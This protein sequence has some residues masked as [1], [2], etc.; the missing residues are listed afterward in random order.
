MPTYPLQGQLIDGARL[1]EW[2]K[3]HIPLSAD[4][5]D[6]CSAF[7]KA[8]ALSK[9]LDLSS[10]LSGR[11][12]VRWRLSDIVAGVSDLSAYGLA[13]E[14]GLNVFLRL[15]F[16]GKVYALYGHAIAVGSANATSAGLALGSNSN[17][18]VATIVQASSENRRIVDALFVGATLITPQLFALLEQAVAKAQL[19]ESPDSN[20]NWPQD[21]SLLLEP[22]TWPARLLLSECF[23][24]APLSNAGA[25]DCPTVDLA[26]DL[27]LMGFQSAP[28]TH[29][30]AAALEATSMYRWLLGVLDKCG[31]EIY[32]GNL[33]AQLHAA[34]LEDPTPSRRDVK[35]LV[36][37][38]IEWITAS[39]GR[40][41]QIDRPNYSQR[42]W[43][44]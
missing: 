42:I 41:V 16:H 24:S 1:G 30:V 8:D 27:Q 25:F 35:V 19:I 26:H 43:L 22:S 21:V 37:N 34:L 18:E 31:G 12:L 29:Q 2:L 32:F 40:K 9:L 17:A 4:S 38:L 6:I 15:D 11:L 3:D 5:I 13:R 39:G 23:M 36:Q 14:A 33:S 10:S 44:S 20:L 7:V 28:R